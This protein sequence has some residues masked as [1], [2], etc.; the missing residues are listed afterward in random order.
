MKKKGG[1]RAFALALA[2]EGILRVTCDLVRPMEVKGS[3]TSGVLFLS[4]CGK[5]RG[6]GRKGGREEVKCGG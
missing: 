1:L 2:A 3:E 4:R 5:R 6:K